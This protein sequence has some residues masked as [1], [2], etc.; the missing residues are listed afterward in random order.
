MRGVRK[1]V[2]NEP[3][4]ALPAAMRAVAKASGITLQ[5]D[6]EGVGDDSL[7]SFCAASYSRAHFFCSSLDNGL[8][9]SAQG[10]SFTEHLSRP[11][12]FSRKRGCWSRGQSVVIASPP[13]NLRGLPS[14]E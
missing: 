5:V 4:I 8:W 9:H 13:P 12:A 1:I 3:T 14:F 11:L 10:Q 2:N 6:P 7:R